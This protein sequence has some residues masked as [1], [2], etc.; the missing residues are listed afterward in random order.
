[1]IDIIDSAGR[2]SGLSIVAV[3][4]A[5][6]ILFQLGL[7]MATSY[8]VR[9]GA[10]ISF[11]WDGK[12]ELAR[13]VRAHGNFCEYV[14]ITL[15]ALVISAFLGAEHW[16]L[17]VVC[18]ALLIGRALHAYGLFASCMTTRGIG[19][20]ATWAAMATAALMCFVLGV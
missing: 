15:V 16:M 3:Y 2:I 14:P 10:K 20:M 4:S 13:I 12:D 5:I 11:G 8:Y 17:H 18:G 1:M 9:A 7:A 6:F 19:Q